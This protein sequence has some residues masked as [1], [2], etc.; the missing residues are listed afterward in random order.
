MRASR[1]LAILIQLQLRGRLT[2]EVLART[3]EVSIRTVYRDVDA[4]CVAG[5]PIRCERGPGGG[6]ELIDGYRTR[7]TGLSADEVEAL[8]VIG[9]PGPAAALGLGGA[10]TQA[11]N[12]LLAALPDS[13]RDHAGRLR[14]RLHLDPVP[15]YQESEPGPH[16]PVLA[17]AVI[18]QQRVHL[19][20]DSWKQV[21]DWTL[22]PLGLVLKAGSWYLVGRSERGIGMYKVQQIRDCCVDTAHFEAPPD[23]DLPE[24]WR[25]QLVQFDTRLRPDRARL[26]VSASG[27]ARLARLGAYAERALAAAAPADATGWTVV[28]LPIEG[29]EQ[30][31]LQLLSLGPEFRVLEP[32]ELRAHLADL[33][34]RM[35]ALLL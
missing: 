32:A 6:F 10:A 25:Q 24:W 8:F 4:L 14:Q 30:T 2:A 7:L 16:L 27:R 9:M 28:D 5:V 19:R 3:F 17:R 22:D 31:A 21:R 13:R 26:A 34:R 33:A 35:H 15:W 20:Y 11:S 23:F 18:A 12:K 29:I 1:L